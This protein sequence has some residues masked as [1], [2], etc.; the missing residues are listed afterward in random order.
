[1]I[2]T[3]TPNA[4]IDKTYIVE[5]FGLDRVH[6]PTECRTVPGGKGINVVRV[7]NELGRAGLAT[8]FVGGRTGDAI[9]EGLDREKIRHDF[10]RVAGESRLCIAVVDP[11]N[12][13]QTEVNE[14]GPD[15]SADEVDAM[16]R[17]VQALVPGKE[18]VV[19]CGSV[20]PGV[21]T[22][23]YGDII[24]IAEKAGVK[25][26][27]DTSGEHLREAI[28]SSPFMVKPNIAELSQLAG[29]E[30]LTLEEISRAAKSLKQYGV[31]ITAVSM[32]RSGAM[33]TDGVQAWK[34]TPPEIQFA[35]AVGSGDSFVAA[36]LD[37]LLRGESLSTALV[38]GTA[39]GAANAA[40]Y[41]AGFCSKESIMNIKQGVVLAKIG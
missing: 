17:N 4:A 1:M 12:G 6:R 14:N 16:L 38:A 28:E 31:A 9:L 29:R 5:G 25:T 35:S 40:T 39:A 13:T 15:I 20:P 41:G 7:L 22:S 3:V 26:V 37:C 21:P 27:L 10:V 23:F 18:F 11:N 34:A 8:G 30:L 2:L 24:K 33:V 32:G 36:F 19:L